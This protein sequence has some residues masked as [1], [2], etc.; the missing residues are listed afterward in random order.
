MHNRSY[1]APII[2]DEQSRKLTATNIYIERERTI[3][4]EEDARSTLAEVG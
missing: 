4:W 3:E 2:A 1:L